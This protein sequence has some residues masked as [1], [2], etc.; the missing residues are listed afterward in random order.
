[1][2]GGQRGDGQPTHA[3]PGYDAAIGAM[4]GL[5]AA[6]LGPSQGSLAP[7]TAGVVVFRG[8]TQHPVKQGAP[9]WQKA[10]FALGPG[11]NRR[12]I[13]F[14][15]SWLRFQNETSATGSDLMRALADLGYDTRNFAPNDSATQGYRLALMARELPSNGDSIYGSLRELIKAGTPPFAVLLGAGGNDF[16][17]G[18]V[19]AVKPYCVP[20]GTD[21]VLDRVLNRKGV[22]P[23]YNQ[24]TLDEFLNMMTGHLSFI[25]T[26]LARAGGGIGSPTQVPIVVH[27]YDHP[28]PDGTGYKMRSCPWL[29]PNFAR[30]CYTSADLTITAGLMSTFIDQLNDAYAHTINTLAGTG[31]RVTFVRLTG[32]LAATTEYQQYGFKAVWKNEMHPNKT[33]FAAL[34]AHL[35]TH[36]LMPLVPSMP[37]I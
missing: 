19:F 23:S 30:K 3:C 8:T 18:S 13:G 29:E 15:D 24:Q 37:V 27:A 35:H 22:T 25:V 32:V 10:T 5:V 1:M 33:G 2:F 17:D 20:Y 6:L 4:V 26:E 36:G 9:S 31:I 11:K 21:S 34:A 16:V 12:L 14:G 7:S 28:T